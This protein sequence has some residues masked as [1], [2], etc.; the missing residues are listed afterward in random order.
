AKKVY[1]KYDELDSNQSALSQKISQT[2]TKFQKNSHDDN[3]GMGGGSPLSEEILLEVFPPKFKIPTLKKYDG[4]SNPRS[5]LVNFHTM[6]L[7]QNVNNFI[8][9]RAFPTTLTALAQKWYQSLPYGFIENF[10]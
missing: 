1:F 3:Y 7:L 5:H 4:T 8:L 9:C 2:I 10:E 6:I